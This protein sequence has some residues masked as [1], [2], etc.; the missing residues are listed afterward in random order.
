[1]AYLIETSQLIEFTNHIG[2]SGDVD[3]L[4]GILTPLKMTGLFKNAIY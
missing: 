2:Y 3:P 1:M 4:P